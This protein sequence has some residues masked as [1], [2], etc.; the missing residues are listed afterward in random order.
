ME[1][2]KKRG[3]WALVIVLMA[4]LLAGILPAGQAKA[5]FELEEGKYY[6][7][8]AN[9]VDWVR[10]D[11]VKDYRG[12]EP[13]DSGLNIADKAVLIATSG[14]TMMQFQVNSWSTY[15]ALYMV[16]Q[17]QNDKIASLNF[18]SVGTGKI[19]A[20]WTNNEGNA[21]TGFEDMKQAGY[22]DESYNNYYEKLIPAQVDESSDTAIFLLQNV[23]P[24]QKF[25]FVGYTTGKQ[26]VERRCLSTSFTLDA[27][28]ATEASDF[29]RI[30]YLENKVTMYPVLSRNT[31]GKDTYDYYDSPRANGIDED[32][33]YFEPT[34]DYTAADGLVTV[35]LKVTDAFKNSGY[36]KIQSIASRTGYDESKQLWSYTAGNAGVN[37]S[38]NLYDAASGTVTL[39]MKTDFYFGTPV[40]FTN[41]AGRVSRF[42]LH[43]TPKAYGNVTVTNEAT[44]IT[45][46]NNSKYLPETAKLEVAVNEDQ[47]G[48]DS[49]AN[50]ASE[51]D[52]YVYSF[53]LK[54]GDKAWGPRLRSTVKI[55]IPEGWSDDRFFAEIYFIVNYMGT[56]IIQYPFDWDMNGKIQEENGQKYLVMSD[57]SPEVLNSGGISI[58]QTNTRQDV[59]KLEAG[60]YKT[61]VRFVRAGTES[62]LSMANGTLEQE[63]YLT[64]AQDGTKE[65]YMNFHGLDM[66]TGEEGYAYMGALWNKSDADVTYYDYETEADGAL[67]NNAAFDAVTEFA[68][69][70][71]AKVTLSDDTWNGDELKYAFKVIPPAMGSGD[72]YDYVYNNPI[73]ADLVFYS[74]EKVD[75]GVQIPTYQKSVLRRAIDQ[76]KNFDGAAY[77]QESFKVLTDALADAQTYYEGLKD[78]DAGTDAAISNTIQEKTA[79]IQ[80]AIAGLK[81][82]TE[83]ADA[84]AALKTAIDTA[85]KV[86][87]G[88]KTDSAYQALQ[89]AIDTA[90]A[91]YAKSNT[92]V[93][94]LKNAADTLKAAV[95]TFNNSGSASELDKHN[96]KA[97]DYTVHIDML[98]ASNPGQKSMS[99]NAVD[100]TAKLTV[101]DQGKYT[102]TLTFK[103]MTINLGGNAF[104]GY[105]KELSYFADGYTT[106]GGIQGE[107]LPAEVLST[108]KDANGNPVADSYND[109]DGD[110]KVDYEYPEQLRFELVPTAIQDENGYAALRVFVPIMDA[111]SQGTGT[112]NVFMHID[113]SS[114]AADTTAQDQAAAKAVTDQI[115]ALGEIT[116]LD[117]A[118]AVQ[119]ARAAYDALTD[120]QKAY[121]A[122]D[123]L[124]VLA[125]AEKAIA[126]LKAEAEADKA[127]QEAAAKV[128]ALIEALP[129]TEDLALTDQTQVTEARAAYEAL[130][131]RAKSYVKA[132]ETLKAAEA[133]MN[134]LKQAAADA[135]VAQIVT[136]QINAL[137]EITSLDQSARVQAARAAYDALTDAQK[138]YVTEDTL[139]VLTDA[140]AKLAALE[141]AKVEA[142]K[143][144]AQT[145]ADQISA[146]GQITSLDQAQAVQDAR[147]AYDALTADQKAYVSADSLKALDAAEEAIIDL[148][149]QAADQAAADAVIKQIVA[150]KAADELTLE[151]KAS[152]TAA[153]SAYNALT[154]SQKALVDAET[155]KVLTDAET[156]IA[157]LEAAANPEQPGTENKPGTTQSGLGTN[158]LP[159]NSGK[160]VS[161]NAKT[162]VDT[163]DTAAAVAC[164]LMALAGAVAFGYGQKKK[165]N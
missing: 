36:T 57:V 7:A 74:V 76:G 89:A 62:Q 153:R 40:Y 86:E 14:G 19:G 25:G 4:A 160:A 10:D 49:I 93:E 157:E 84:R 92:T 81:E 141:A 163:S 47:V 80:T 60:T 110:G 38:D 34:S 42:T 67:K 108:I 161:G 146:L 30:Q 133:Q 101:D 23:D 33:G 68:C 15:E 11:Y 12:G 156:K 132:L 55:P 102:I 124:K 105:L 5:A 143:A 59:S 13:K 111:I 35:T 125:D 63:A 41:E 45:V 164:G 8:W 136:D 37:L 159:Q 21:L 22:V 144:A 115:A 77:S 44:G 118:Q 29:V 24:N 61:S 64:V 149:A 79:A 43:L 51:G 82:N 100:H 122:A 107:L 116:S 48:I 165:E 138:A 71:S 6:Y 18:S 139:K 72:P 142:D 58:A 46:S 70:K 117:Q 120:S 9:T 162:G 151:D 155:L 66:G 97:G 129:A 154:D 16:K 106:S 123:S 131:D 73:D 65:I 147:A 39:Q 99:D 152:V 104:F 128:D 31:S 121:V 135:E 52:Y 112:Q 50:V 75:D 2:L 27:N 91:A 134:V 87:Q 145:V 3:L 53:K 103:G 20:N 119:D 109:P 148:K 130:N 83:L 28:L 137:G 17:R 88:D 113:W 85:A 56:D 1:V 114:L 150:L 90:E 96:L 69:V 94:E 98:N 126:D 127:D 95:D 26:A 32:P 54:N 158:K 78:K 140:E